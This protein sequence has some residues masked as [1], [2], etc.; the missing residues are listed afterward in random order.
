[1]ADPKKIVFSFK[2]GLM[3]IVIEVF[4]GAVFADEHNNRFIAKKTFTI[5]RTPHREIY[6]INGKSVSKHICMRPFDK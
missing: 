1:M 3:T 4:K 5:R 6:M 2:K